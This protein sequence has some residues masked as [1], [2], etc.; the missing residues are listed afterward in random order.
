MEH[1]QYYRPAGVVTDPPIDTV[2]LPHDLRHLRRKLLHL[3]N[4]GMV[5]LDLKEA[6]MFHHGD[7]LILDNGDTIEIHAA[8]EKLYEINARDARHLVEI[9]W[10]LGNRHLS[11]Q[12][13]EDRIL[14]L[15]DHVI[16]GMLEGL[17][18][19]VYDVEE[20]F[21][22][23]RGAHSHGHDHGHVHG[24]GCNHD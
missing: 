24:P 11:V 12:I 9:A 20:P 1:I 10:H 22:P 2:S 16:R 21:Q 13:E 23:A 15:R 8:P 14:I 19:K 7:R 3:S 5:M 18:A 4:G 6:V 17:G